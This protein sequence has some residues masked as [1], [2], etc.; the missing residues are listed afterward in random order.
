M[1]KL[2]DRYRTI[3]LFNTSGKVLKT[4]INK[5]NVPVFD[6]NS[7]IIP[8]LNS[9]GYITKINSNTL[10]IIIFSAIKTKNKH[11]EVSR[12]IEIK[13]WCLLDSEGWIDIA[14]KDIEKVEKV[15]KIKR[16]GKNKIGMQNKKLN[17][18]Y[19]LRI[20]KRIHPKY[21]KMLREWNKK[22]K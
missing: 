17:Y 18:S 13:D 8:I 20:M 2:S 16:Q 10:R 7:C 12:F 22:D 9:S 6:P 4:D 11:K 1:K 15:L 19:F 14:Y 21:D 5:D 3:A